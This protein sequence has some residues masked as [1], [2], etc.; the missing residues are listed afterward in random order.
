[1]LRVTSQ[2]ECYLPESSVSVQ[3]VQIGNLR[4]EEKGL[5]SALGPLF[6]QSTITWI[7]QTCWSIRQSPQVSQACNQKVGRPEV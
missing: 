7:G 5:Q 3:L 2:G 1:M 6:L 4:T